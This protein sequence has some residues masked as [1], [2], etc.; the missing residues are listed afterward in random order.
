MKKKWTRIS[1]NL[2]L[3]IVG[4]FSLSVILSFIMGEINSLSQI[5]MGLLYLVIF[6]VLLYFRIT[7]YKKACV[8]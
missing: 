5:V 6:A 8:K 7:L 4:F 2:I 1:F 3:I